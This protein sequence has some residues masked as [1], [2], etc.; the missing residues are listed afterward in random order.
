MVAN[1]SGATILFTNLK[2]ICDTNFNSIA[3]E[4]KKYPN[5]IPRIIQMKI[6][7]VSEIFLK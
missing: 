5:N 2:N 7:F 1:I 3:I 4:G 6:H